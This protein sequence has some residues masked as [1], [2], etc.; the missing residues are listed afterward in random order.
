MPRATRYTCLHCEREFDCI[1]RTMGPCPGCED[2][3]H[4]GE[5]PKNCPACQA[6]SPPEA[7][8]KPSAEKTKR[9][10][11]KKPAVPSA[12]PKT[13]LISTL[14][15]MAVI[16]DNT[17]IQRSAEELLLAYIGDDDIRAAYEPFMRDIG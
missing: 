8:E 3:G 14:R 15:G 9:P 1:D 17:S 13:T 5:L 2:L 4:A 6:D 7:A 10:R 11:G 16:A 12:D